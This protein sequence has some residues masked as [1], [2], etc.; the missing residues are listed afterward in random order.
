V[1]RSSPHRI[2]QITMKGHPQ[3]LASLLLYDIDPAAL[4]VLGCHKKYVLLS[5]AS[6][7]RQEHRPQ[8]VLS[9]VLS[10]QTVSP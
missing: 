1:S 3:L 2:L 6:V 9:R 8:R 4:D 7:S 5:L 10:Y